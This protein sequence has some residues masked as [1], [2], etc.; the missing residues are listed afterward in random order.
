MKKMFLALPLVLSFLLF[1][2]SAIAQQS[3]SGPV[4][5]GASQGAHK[6]SSGSSAD[7]MGCKDMKALH[8]QMSSHMEDMDK[9]LDE[10]VSAMNAASGDQKLAAM[11]AVLNEL[12][13]QRK[14]MREDFKKMHTARMNCMKS[15]RHARGH[16]SGMM[17]GENE[18]S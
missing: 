14:E 6:H 11:A 15:D 17:S 7:M 16:G 2:F 13:T 8:E 9:R 1:A 5:P 12:A 18:K 3:K 10:K 4:A